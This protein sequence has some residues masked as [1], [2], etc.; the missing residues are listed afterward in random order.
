MGVSRATQPLASTCQTKV[1]Q[2]SYGLSFYGSLLNGDEV[3][4][5]EGAGTPVADGLLRLYLDEDLRM[6][7]RLRGEFVLAI[8]DGKARQLHL[9]TDRFRII[10]L[11]YYVDDDRLLFASRLGSIR[12]WEHVSLTIDPRA[13]VDVMAFSSIPTPRTIFREIRKLPPG[14]VLTYGQGLVRLAPYWDINFLKPDRSGEKALSH[15]LK[16]RF[17]D[18]LTMSLKRD[19]TARSIGTFL[20]GGVDSS[21]VTGQLCALSPRPIQ[22]FSI[23]FGEERFNEISFARIAASHFG[24]QHHEY[25]VTPEDTYNAIP[26]LCKSFDEPFANASSIAAYYCAKLGKDHGVDVLYAG[27]GGDELFA[28]NERYREQRRFEYYDRIPPWARS[29]VVKPA[30]SMLARLTNFDFFVKGVKYIRRAEER[31][32][33]RLSTYGLFN[34]VPPALLFEGDL[35][36]QLNGED[37]DPYE[38]ISRYYHQALADQE[39]DRQLYVDLKLAIGDNDLIKVTSMAA[40]AGVV[41]RFPFLDH[42]LAE[43]AATVPA[44]LKMQGCKLRTFFKRAYSDL[45]PPAVLTKTKHGFG[46]PIPIWLRTDTRLN[47]M[48]MDLV[49]GPRSVQRGYFRKKTL[50]ELVSRHKIDTTSFYGT[51][52]WNLMVLELWHRTHWHLQA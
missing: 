15:E 25:F 31:Y 23:G 49:L 26:V 37:Q 13:I 52:L 8:W 39:L 7:D 24:I 10:P 1:H 43:F 50:E 47:G 3:L 2:W 35:L 5:T 45:L 44:E 42:R 33:K 11:F 40:A 41:V 19:G 28:G 48:M 12:A 51:I 17:T 14:Y 4:G 21:T 20:S 18:V 22:S 6:L 38:P 27:D 34:V 29:L 36:A 32:P 46:L 16:R 30:V 9:A